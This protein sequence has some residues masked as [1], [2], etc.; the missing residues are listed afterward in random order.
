MKSDYKFFFYFSRVKKAQVLKK[1]ILKKY[2]QH[3]IKNANLIVVFGGDGFMLHTI[4][5]FYKYKKPFFGI[6]CGNFGFL[7][8]EFNSLNLEK[9]IKKTK[10][11]LI[12]PL[13]AD[14]KNA[15]GKKRLIAIN[16]FSFLRQT[17]QTSNLKI[18]A[19]NKIFLKNLIGD[20]LII[21]TPIGST[22]YNFSAGGPL[23][24]INSNKISLMPLNP[25]RSKY[26]KGKIFN[27]KSIFR[28]TNKRSD[29]PI[30]ITGD[31]KEIRNLSYAKIYC[32]KK[33]NILLMLNKNRN[34]LK[35]INS[36]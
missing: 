9:E 19:N 30:S 16:E 34:F 4:Q 23:L 6:N 24:K 8:N 13:K 20:G 17:K 5:K 36:N 22:G 33:I 31:N 27:D 25:F 35:K 10:I 15:F 14:I 29:R 18:F 28:I 1:K 2:K 7:L 21:S 32:E 11:Q 3:N 26:R 12:H